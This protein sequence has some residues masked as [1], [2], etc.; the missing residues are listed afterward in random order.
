MAPLKANSIAK[1]NAGRN[2]FQNISPCMKETNY[3][4]IICV[5]VF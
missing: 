1:R 3:N 2:R 4:L 5:F